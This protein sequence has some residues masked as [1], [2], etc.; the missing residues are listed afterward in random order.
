MKISDLVIGD[1]Y[2]IKLKTKNKPFTQEVNGTL[3]LNFAEGLVDVVAREKYSIYMDSLFVYLGS[4][5]VRIEKRLD[6]KRLTV[7]NYKPHYM[8]CISTNEIVLI[9]G[10][11]IQALFTKPE[12]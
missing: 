11:Y 12:K 7:Y 5:S 6:K 2:K 10:Y 3:V 9:R 1:L 8:L 4:K